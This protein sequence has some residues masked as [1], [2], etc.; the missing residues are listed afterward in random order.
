MKE[1]TASTSNKKPILKQLKV[2]VK[3]ANERYRYDVL[4]PWNEKS[5]QM[6]DNQQQQGTGCTLSQGG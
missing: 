3:F 1:G 6:T 5:S 2:T 4:F